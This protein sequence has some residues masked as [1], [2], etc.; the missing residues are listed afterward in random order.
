[1]DWLIVGDPHVTHKSLGR[2]AQLFEI[3]ESYGLPVIWTGDLL[4]T[5]EVIRGKCLN[6]FFDYFSKSRLNHIV[7][8]GNHDWFN[9]EC[10]DHSLKTLSALP[11][12]NVIDKPTVLGSITFLPYM[13]NLA[14]LQEE[15]SKVNTRTLIA[16][17]DVM[18]FDYGDGALCEKGLVLEDFKH[19]SGQ[20]I[21]G[22]F[23]KYQTKGNLT[24][25]GSPFSHTFGE[26]DQTK[27]L[28]QLM[29]NGTLIL[30]ETGLA[31]HVTLELDL[32]SPDHKNEVGEF[33]AKN[34]H[35]FVR[36]ELYGTQSQISQF[37]RQT[38]EIIPIKWVPKSTEEEMNSV[39]IAEGMDT[40]QQFMQWAKEVK[41]L[42]QATLGLGLS[43]LEAV[44]VK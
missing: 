22:H 24:Y 32:S 30:K 42:D 7:L 3:V 41:K 8:V 17:A 15:V 5:K 18:D 21:S 25:I 20:V 37:N 43:I 29:S 23:H 34:L 40:R 27:Y 6:A 13:H 4:D 36:I 11:N 28:G 35:N 26:S 14:L 33:I 16:H 38:Y 9:L 2:A 39:V 31:R 12:V 1:M 19:I 10:K 44:S